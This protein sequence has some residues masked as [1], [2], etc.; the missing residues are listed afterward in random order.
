VN[1][2]NRSPTD[3]VVLEGMYPSAVSRRSTPFH[4]PMD[5]TSWQP[6]MSG[7]GD[8]YIICGKK[9]E[10]QEG[11]WAGFDPEQCSEDPAI[12]PSGCGS[13]ALQYVPAGR[14]L[15]RLVEAPKT[16]APVKARETSG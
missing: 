5:A 9:L 13:S 8:G 12:R 4:P 11:T 10:E 15:P 7:H 1:A 16:P 6:D 14:E 3:P 2:G